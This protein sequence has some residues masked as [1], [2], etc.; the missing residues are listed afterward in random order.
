MASIR[1]RGKTWQADARVGGRRLRKAFDTRGAAESFLGDHEPRT[2]RGELTVGKLLREWFSTREAGLATSRRGPVSPGTLR[3]D[4]ECMRRIEDTGLSRVQVIRL[5]QQDLRDHYRARSRTASTVSIN[6]EARV[7]KSALAWAANSAGLIDRVPV[8]LTGIGSVRD[9]IDPTTLSNAQLERLLAVCDPPLRA[10]VALCRFAGLRRTEALTL[11]GRDLDCQAGSIHVRA[12]ILEDGTRWS[13]KS[14]QR[15]VVPISQRLRA[16]LARYVAAERGPV[17]ENEWLFLRENDGGRLRN[18]EDR[19]RRAYKRAGL[20]PQGLHVLRRS[21][22][23]RLAEHGVSAETVRRLGGWS[24]LEVIQRSYF[25]VG[26]EA[27]RAAIE[28]AD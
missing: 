19:V 17:G 16:E 1:R 9:D 28:L 2:E 13:P 27:M 20:K 11:Q 5:T 26:E 4:R 18:V 21:W 23:T 10:I 3:N 22:A 7:L 8:T 14:K 24:S 6:R 15:R 12:K 25:N